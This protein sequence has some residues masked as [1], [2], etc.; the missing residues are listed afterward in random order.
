MLT[1]PRRN[2]STLLSTMNRQ[3]EQQQQQKSRSDE[4]NGAIRSLYPSRIEVESIVIPDGDFVL[5]QSP[6]R[7]VSTIKPTSPLTI[8]THGACDLS[9]FLPMARQS[10]MQRDLSSLSILSAT[11]SLDDSSMATSTM[12][13]T[14]YTT[15]LIIRKPAV[16]GG[17]TASSSWHQS[18]YRLEIPTLSS[19]PT[20][21]VAPP[22]PSEEKKGD[23][24]RD[25]ASTAGVAFGVSNNAPCSPNNRRCIE[26]TPGT[27]MPLIGTD[28][29]KVAMKEGRMIHTCCLM[30]NL[31]VVC[32][33]EADCV[34]CPSCRGISPITSSSSSYRSKQRQRHRR[35]SSSNGTVGLGLSESN[36]FQFQ[37]E[38][39]QSFTTTRGYI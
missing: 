27:Y 19:S 16:G 2:S 33:D 35:N 28:E 8:P 17:G 9:N 22:P 1:H 21:T 25:S 29:T 31:Q 20:T 12:S 6:K 10:M 26:V 5:S 4:C 14:A 23:Q 18:I 34:L 36:Y 30:C 37:R 38:Q 15:P 13:S 32:T 24:V 3:Q 39:E 11:P 7:R